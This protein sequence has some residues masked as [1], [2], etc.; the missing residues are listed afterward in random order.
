MSRITTS[1][2]CIVKKY[3]LII[4]FP[5]A[6]HQP[7]KYIFVSKTIHENISEVTIKKGETV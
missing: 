1:H 3:S 4:E 7:W 5:D 2:D 6:L